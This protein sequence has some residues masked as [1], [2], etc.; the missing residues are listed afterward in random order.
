MTALTYQR[1][2]WVRIRSCAF[3]ERVTAWLSTRRTFFLLHVLGYASLF[4]I[5]LGH[6]LPWLRAGH[7]PPDL[8]YSP[9]SSPAAEILQTLTLCYLFTL[10]YLSLRD[11]RRLNFEAREIAW[12]AV[13]FA[14]AA[15][16]LLPANSTD[17]FEY[18]GLGRLA[19]VYGVNPYLH[20]YS[21]ATH[22]RRT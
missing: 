20:S 8:G 7:L 1:P 14:V 18:I 6:S 12:A 22:S 17:I 9:M 13:I 4:L 19:A 11:W 16:S 10:Y 21:T 2:A 3:N 5:S 15:W